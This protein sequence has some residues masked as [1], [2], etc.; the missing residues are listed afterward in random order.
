MQCSLRDQAAARPQRLNRAKNKEVLVALVGLA[1]VGIG[2]LSVAAIA[3]NNDKD[4]SASPRAT[5]SP[6]TKPPT[7]VKTL[8]DPAPPKADPAPPKAQAADTADQMFKD[9]DEFAN[10]FNTAFG[11]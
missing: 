5:E 11:D 10:T 3:E 2:G 8:D 7:P 9:L 4:V 6:T 1:L